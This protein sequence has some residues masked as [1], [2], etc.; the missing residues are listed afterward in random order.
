M[1]KCGESTGGVP[2]RNEGTQSLFITDRLNSTVNSSTCFSPTEH[3]ALLYSPEKP[4]STQIARLQPL[5]VRREETH[6]DIFPSSQPVMSD[7]GANIDS[8]NGV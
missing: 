5:C 6:A 4:R 3:S 8:E 7:H 2:Q 1:S